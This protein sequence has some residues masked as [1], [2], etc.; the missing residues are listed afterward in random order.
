MALSES[1]LLFIAQPTTKGH[2]RAN[3]SFKKSTSIAYT[4]KKKPWC[5]Q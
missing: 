1:E 5:E 2:L 3:G 4:H